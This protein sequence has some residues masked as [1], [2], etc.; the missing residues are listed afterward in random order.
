MSIS[1]IFRQKKEPWFIQ[2]G[3][4]W[5]LSDI[6]DSPTTSPKSTLKVQKKVINHSHNHTKDTNPTSQTLKTRR[7]EQQ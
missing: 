7:L 1:D 3:R 2:K 4:Q 6:Y 5:D